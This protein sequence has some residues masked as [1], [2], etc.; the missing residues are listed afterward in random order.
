MA[1]QFKQQQ[2]SNGLTVVAECDDAAHTSAVGFFVRAGSRDESREVMGVSHFLEHMVFKGSERR[3]AADVNREFDEIGANYNAYTSQEATVFYGQVLPEMLPRAVDLI[4]DLL[5]PSLRDEDF[6]VEKQVILEEIGM[7]EDRPALRLQEHLLEKHF[8]E[9]P[10][11]HRVLGTPESIQALTAVQMRQY[12][13][14]RYGADSIIV[15]AGGKLDFAQLIDQLEDLTGRWGPTGAQRRYD[16]PVLKSAEHTLADPR[17]SRHYVAM[18]CPAPSTQDERRYAARVLA[19]VI[20][21]AD[22]SRFYWNLIDPG[23]ADEAEFS[24][25]SAD[26]LGSYFAFAS[27]DVKRSGQVEQIMLR[28][29]DDYAASIDDG[30]IERARNKIATESTVRGETPMGRMQSV[31]T[32]WLYL[33]DYTPLEEEVQRILAVTPDQVRELVEQ[34]PFQPRTLCRLC[35][36]EDAAAAKRHQ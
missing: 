13:Q 10:L 25:F 5:C 3:S 16:E 31:G 4:A 12:F 7:Y 2:L 28:T 30:E 34:M 20:G 15:A 19:D 29:L 6:E 11:A 26:R 27:C 18:L 35:P 9:H 36:G 1:I 8:G 22:G 21:D 23:L 32:R 17:L 33:N 14:Q 24:Y